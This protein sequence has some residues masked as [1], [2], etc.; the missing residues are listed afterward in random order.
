MQKLKRVF[1]KRRNEAQSPGT[2]K[3]KTVEGNAGSS[4]MSRIEIAL[5]FL[6]HNRIVDPRPSPPSTHAAAVAAARVATGF[7][8]SIADGSITAQNAHDARQTPIKSEDDDRMSQ[9]HAKP[10]GSGEDYSLSSQKHDTIDRRHL[11][12]SPPNIETLTLNEPQT[13]SHNRASSDPNSVYSSPSGTISGNNVTTV[14]ERMA[15]GK[16]GPAVARVAC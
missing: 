2:V 16:P 4:G 8:E 3:A 5:T 7:A 15:P 1:H 6:P 10:Y 11:E 12:E 9:S 14:E 13:F